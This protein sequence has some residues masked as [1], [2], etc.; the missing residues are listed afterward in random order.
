MILGEN[1]WPR[2]PGGKRKALV[3]SYDD[4][5]EHDRRLVEIFNRHGIRATF[6]LNSGK[7]DSPHHISQQEVRTLYVGHEVACHTVSHP[8]LTALSLNEVRR[9]VGQD[10]AFLEDLLGQPVRGL[11]YPF[12]KYN[13]QVVG[14]MSELQM[15][16]GR[17]TCITGRFGLPQTPLELTTTGHHNSAFALGERFLGDES[18]GL[19]FM[20]LWGHSYELDGFMSGDRTR[21]WR[22]MEAFC[23]L[24]SG[25]PEIYYGTTVEVVD[26]LDGMRQ[27][28]WTGRPRHLHNPSA[29]SLW[30]IWGKRCLEIPPGGKIPIAEPPGRNRSTR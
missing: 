4:G 19:V 14:I 30:V 6:H 16:Y 25:N 15:A 27:L 2:F 20:Y 13:A 17:T 29:L 1:V 26:Y 21:D 24:I 5:S 28:A 10:R 11:A 12:G 3:M 22:Y 18:D 8:D 23:R 7:L 9:E